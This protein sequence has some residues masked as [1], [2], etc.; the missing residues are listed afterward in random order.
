MDKKEHYHFSLYLD[1]DTAAKFRAKAF[2]ENRDMTEVVRDWIN[3][4]ISREPQEKQGKTKNARGV[5]F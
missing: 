5:G 4:Y 2:A 3:G 1:R